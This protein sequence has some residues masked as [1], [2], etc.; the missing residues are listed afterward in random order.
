[1]G[2][3]SS[4]RD[5]CRLDRIG[6]GILTRGH[7]VDKLM[8]EVGVRATMPCS[9]GKGQVIFSGISSVDSPGG[10]GGNFLWKQMPKVGRLNFFW[11]LRLGLFGGVHHQWFA[12]DER[13]FNR[14]L[15]PIDLERF[16]ILASHIK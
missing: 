16:P 15:F 10:E 5:I 6:I 13:P 12:L 9:L 1:M 11:N 8:G 4:A 14:F 3:D 2:E 7:H